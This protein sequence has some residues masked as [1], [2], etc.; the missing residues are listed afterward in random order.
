MQ[1]SSQHDSAIPQ[2]SQRRADDPRELTV[3]CHL[4][5]FPAEQQQRRTASSP[6]SQGNTKQCVQT[7]ENAP[8]DGYTRLLQPLTAPP[9]V[10]ATQCNKENTIIAGKRSGVREKQRISSASTRPDFEVLEEQSSQPPPCTPYLIPGCRQRLSKYEETGFGWDQWEVPL[11]RTDTA[12]LLV[13]PMYDKASVYMG[14][15]EFQF[16]EIRM[17]DIRARQRRMTQRQLEAERQPRPPLEL[18]RLERLRHSEV[19]AM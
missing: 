9:L 6:R 13:R 16:E 4:P 3:D 8:R 18:H 15:T 7:D 2:G 12:G 5:I 14:T 17:A 10:V 1:Q 11:C 19:K